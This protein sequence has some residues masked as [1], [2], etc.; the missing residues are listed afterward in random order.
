MISSESGG[1]EELAMEQHEEVKEEEVKS[2][3]IEEKAKDAVRELQKTL[4]LQM[5][6]LRNRPT[7]RG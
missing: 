7:V 2:K 4:K 3:A 5:K 1:I 6:K